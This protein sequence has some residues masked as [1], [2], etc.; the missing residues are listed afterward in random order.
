MQY[1]N[2]YA[3]DKSMVIEEK[4]M[5]PMEIGRT[6]SPHLEISTVLRATDDTQGT[7]GTG[8]FTIPFI[9]VPITWV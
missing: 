5:L 8:T 2:I 3:K 7:V 6:T 1:A 4:R 9:R